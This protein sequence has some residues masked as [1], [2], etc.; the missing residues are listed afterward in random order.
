MIRLKR[1][2]IVSGLIL[3]MLCLMPF[4][5]TEAKADS[6]GITVDGEDVG[7]KSNGDGWSYDEAANV[8]TLDGYVRTYDSEDSTG[9]IWTYGKDEVTICLKGENHITIDGEERFTMIFGKK[10][11]FTGDGSY[12]VT[13]SSDAYPY[14]DCTEN[15]TVKSGTIKGVMLSSDSVLTIEDGTIDA[16]WAGGNGWGALNGENVSVKGGIIHAKGISTDDKKSNPI[17]AKQS[18]TVSGGEIDAEGQVFSAGSATI[19]GGSINID[20]DSIGIV[21]NDGGITINGGSI[22]ASCNSHG[23]FSVGNISITDGKI[24]ITCTSD[25]II[26]YGNAEIAGGS[27]EITAAG[28]VY[29]EESIVITDGEF[30]YIPQEDAVYALMSETGIYTIS[31]DAKV[32][33]DKFFAYAMIDGK[34]MLFPLSYTVSYNVNQLEIVNGLFEQYDVKSMDFLIEQAKFIAEQTGLS[35]KE[36]PYSVCF[37]VSMVTGVDLSQ[38]VEITIPVSKIMAGD[39]IAVLH[40][41]DKG[42]F[43]KIK[44]KAEDEFVTGTFTSLSPIVVAKVQIETVSEGAHKIVSDGS[45]ETGDNAG[46]GLLFVLALVSATLAGVTV[47]RKNK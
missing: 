1:R 30:K 44:A 43:E 29:A 27:V 37:D 16:V 46:I 18:F 25:G 13:S 15:L 31:P 7:N 4:M 33:G 32:T 11:T 28:A 36:V 8:L 5:V 3:S 47:C 17:S 38:G 26:T 22:T 14:I 42:E 40:M 19:S 21:T 6:I 23:F 39:E 20:S 45:H 35:V 10:I 34:K 12:E 2:K 41:T 9:F 24:K